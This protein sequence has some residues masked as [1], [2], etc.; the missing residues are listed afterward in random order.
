MDLETT[1]YSFTGARVGLVTEEWSGKLNL[2]DCARYMENPI[3]KEPA[4]KK[5]GPW[6]IS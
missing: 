1:R 3:A 5:E 6:K 4:K 2:A